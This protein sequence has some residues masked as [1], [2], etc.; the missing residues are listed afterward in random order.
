MHLAFNLKTPLPGI[1]KESIRYLSRSFLV[2]LF[3]VRKLT[4][5]SNSGLVKQIVA[6]LYY[7]TNH[8][9]Q[10]YWT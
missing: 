1:P 7:V 3:I 10:E 4:K 5:I 6:H 8:V 9:I 2:L